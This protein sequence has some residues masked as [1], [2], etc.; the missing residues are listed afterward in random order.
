MKL[1]RKAMV[2]NIRSLVLALA[3]VGGF[4]ALSAKAHA[5]TTFSFVQFPSPSGGTGITG[6]A[7]GA[8]ATTTITGNAI[9]VSL[10]FIV[11][12]FPFV[13]DAY[14]SFDATSTGPA[15]STGPVVDYIGFGPFQ[16]IAQPYAGS[17][18]ITN[19]GQLL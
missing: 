12:S 2:A 6:V 19:G 9:P 15:V 14:L 13:P 16:P 7:N 10:S 18:S 11:H 1:S 4:T 17:F 8:G 3:L 5:G